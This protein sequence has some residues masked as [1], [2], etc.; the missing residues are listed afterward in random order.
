MNVLLTVSPRVVTIMYMEY[1]YLCVY[2]P[3][4]RQ[5]VID[6]LGLLWRGFNKKTADRCDMFLLTILQWQKRDQHGLG[7]LLL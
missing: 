3:D 7:E 1:T 5:T 4:T 6:S 2:I